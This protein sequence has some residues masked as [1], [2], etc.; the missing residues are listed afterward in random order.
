MGSVYYRDISADFDENGLIVGDTFRIDNY[1]F[2]TDSILT[3][4]RPEGAYYIKYVASSEDDL[5]SNTSFV[6]SYVS[7]LNSDYYSDEYSSN[8]N[9]P[10]FTNRENADI[11]Y[12][13]DNETGTSIADVSYQV[14][15]ENKYNGDLGPLNQKFNIY[16]DNDYDSFEERYNEIVNDSISQIINSMYVDN[17]SNFVF[18]KTSK[19]ELVMSDI[20]AISSDMQ[21]L[22]NTIGNVASSGPVISSEFLLA[23]VG[24]D[25]GASAGPTGEDTGGGSAAFG[26]GY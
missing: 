1:G 11:D 24:E 14:F 22:G 26:S 3:E 12:I 25:T 4:T 10:N 8:N 5:N 16:K 21:L 18:R 17:S 6:W 2:L 7:D 15:Y 23:P 19:S 20:S 9:W 13:T